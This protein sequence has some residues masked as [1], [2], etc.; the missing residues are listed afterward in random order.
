MTRTLALFALLL[1][2]CGDD[3]M[4]GPDAAPTMD[5]SVGQDG[6]P[7]VDP[8][9]AS[10]PDAA[11]TGVN[12]GDGG[13]DA[14]SPDANSP[15][16]GPPPTGVTAR[17]FNFRV[18]D[19]RASCV[20]FDSTL[21]LEASNGTG[22][23]VSGKT[24]TDVTIADEGLS[25]HCFSVSEAFNF[26]DNNTIRY[27][28]GS[29]M[30]VHPFELQNIAN[31]IPE[32]PRG[33]DRF[34]RADATGGGDGSLGDEWTLEEAGRA[35]A[36]GQ[37][38]HVRAG[39]YGDANL[40]IANSGT[41]DSPIRFIGYRNMPGDEPD[42]GWAYPDNTE[43][44]ANVMPLLDGRNE[45]EGRGIETRGS[46]I[47][48]K[49]FQVQ[50][51]QRL[52]FIQRPSS[53]VVVDNVLVNRG[54]YGF[55]QDG[56]GQNNRISNSTVYQTHT[57]GFRMYGD[58]NRIENSRIYDDR[59]N[60]TEE[61]ES[62]SMD[63]YVV[64]KGLSNIVRGCHLERIEQP[65]CFGLGSGC[66]HSGHG[67][68]L[69]ANGG[70]TTEYNLAENIEVVGI[71]LSIEVWHPFVAHNVFRNIRVWRTEATAKDKS[72]GIDILQGAHDNIFDGITV[73]D[74]SFGV[75]FTGPGNDGNVFR[76]SVFSN[77]T[78]T[79]RIDNPIQD[80]AFIGCTFFANGSLTSM[81]GA[82]SSSN[83]QIVNTLISQVP[84]SGDITGFEFRFSNFWAS[85]TTPAGEG[86]TALD[87]TFADGSM[88]DFHFGPA[89][90]V[91]LRE[92][93]EL[94]PGSHYDIASNERTP[95]YSM[96]VYEAD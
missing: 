45:F 27:E 80:N 26:W 10:A 8:S 48:V 15:D 73:N 81:S 95:P 25:G 33:T 39:D 82:A 13:A 6:S 57:T 29:D 62:P 20:M 60:G 70:P 56:G 34:V 1:V 58:F 92:G 18:E 63:Y 47:I 5:S 54:T 68:S 83:N 11:D 42:L 41:P 76:N 24:V 21:P 46:Y 17:L 37:T 69:K 36:A 55:L 74:T 38:V 61:R 96:G 88:G 12:V 22:F 79:M 51:Y 91:E 9:D 30:G 16:A 14:E 23:I 93:G 85:F 94:I 64:V 87:P 4:D 43:F 67:L 19:E 78:T 50:R 66:D 89:S 35:A 75:F 2:A 40:I 32:P 52:F 53:F 7:D 72:G 31:N 3:S 65:E 77:N 71:K 28:G 49:N 90:P 84:R 59:V 44:D 86:N